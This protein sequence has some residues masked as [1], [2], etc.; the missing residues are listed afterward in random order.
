MNGDLF[1]RE[2]LDYQR[3]RLSGQIVLVAERGPMLA[4]LIFAVCSLCFLLVSWE[5]RSHVVLARSCSLVATGGSI[6]VVTEVL[7]ADAIVVSSVLS[8]PSRRQIPLQDLRYAAH[9]VNDGACRI[10]IT[11]EITPFRQILRRLG[12]SKS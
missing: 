12:R 6:N 5:W 11:A 8:S 7:P 1:R 10:L 2:A 3:R 4:A 9:E